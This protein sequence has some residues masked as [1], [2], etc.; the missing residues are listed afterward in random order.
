MNTV[1][2]EVSF[3]FANGFLAKHTR[4][5][6]LED[7]WREAIRMLT[8]MPTPP[9]SLDNAV[10][11][12]KGELDIKGSLDGE[13]ELIAQDVNDPDFKKHVS[14]LRWQ[15]AGILD[16]EGKFYQASEEILGFSEHDEK[17]ALAHLKLL[18]MCV[19]PDAYRRER[20]KFYTQYLPGSIVCFN[21]GPNPVLFRLVCDP[22]F[23]MKTFKDEAAAYADFNKVRPSSLDSI[24]D[25][26]EAVRSDSFRFYL[27]ALWADVLIDGGDYRLP[28][29]DE[30]CLSEL[31]NSYYSGMEQL[32]EIDNAGE[33][34]FD[35]RAYAITH[36]N[37]L[38][39]LQEAAEVMGYQ[40]LI[41]KRAKKVGGY[42]ELPVTTAEGEQFIRV[43]ATPF[44]YWARRAGHSVK[45][46]MKLPDWKPICR[47]G[48]KMMS[49]SAMHTDWWIGAGLPLKD[50]YL[51]DHPVTKAAYRYAVSFARTNGA[52]CLRLA[53]SGKVVGTVVFP[54]KGEGVPAGSIA[55][56][57]NAGTDYEMA[58]LSAC[59]DGAGVVIAGTG[60]KLAHLTTVSRELGARLV[61]VDD[62]MDVFKEGQ[63]VA[64]D[65][66]KGTFEVLIYSRD[67]DD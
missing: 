52:Q 14:Q 42:L 26:A 67:H 53:G 46:E 54:G 23:W 38:E 18:E 35:E 25:N 51:D 57:K 61:V 21:A 28:D 39:E 56:V 63:T 27:E 59:K 50:V 62:A 1:T 32:E 24:G 19:S 4:R 20:A 55:V 48:M 22:P 36:E 33:P 16:V 43:P 3:Q 10:K 60:G 34:A 13:M 5:L 40:L 2:R 15:K 8:E 17:F 29:R 30:D 41:E 58:L 31:L 45:S 6:L 44:L 7:N 37:L 49:D 66:D 65:L 9:L 47:S 12:L 11:V 64:V